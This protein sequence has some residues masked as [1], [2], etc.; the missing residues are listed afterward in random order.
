V[1]L[2]GQRFV[3]VFGKGGV[4]KTVVSA[5]LALALAEEGKRVLLALSNARENLSS[6]LETPPITHEI[7]AVLPGIDAVNIDPA[8]ALVEYGGM[9][10]KVHALNQA[11]FGNRVVMAFLRGTPGIDAWAVL[12]KAY[13]HTKERRPDGSPRYDTVIFDA[14]A[15]GHALDMLRVPMVIRDVAPPGLLRR[16]ADDAL[17]LF[18]DSA[19]SAAFIVTLPEDMPANETRDLHRALT[20]DIGIPVRGIFVNRFLD[21]VFSV[22]EADALLG[23]RATPSI[24]DASP[25]VPYV[26]AARRHA[27]RAAIQAQIVR[28]LGETTGVPLIPI[29]D[30]LVERISRGTLASISAVFREPRAIAPSPRGNASE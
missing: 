25:V 22:P 11:I 13:F 12:G 17:A 3:F 5:A 7:R 16:E 19:R 30:Q 27:R 9:V 29:A 23:I 20:E 26:G 24:D 2:E 14:P 18:Q 4:G 8:H 10:L 28:D 15:T 1:I 6:L 21:P